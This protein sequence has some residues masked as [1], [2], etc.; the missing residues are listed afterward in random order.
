MDVKFEI[1][2]FPVTAYALMVDSEDIAEC[3]VIPVVLTGMVEEGVNAGSFY[4]DVYGILCTSDL[5]AADLYKTDIEAKNALIDFLKSEKDEEEETFLASKSRLS[6][7][8]K[9]LTNLVGI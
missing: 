7:I 3:K 1:K 2:E 5:W 9:S 4:T 8:K 6:L